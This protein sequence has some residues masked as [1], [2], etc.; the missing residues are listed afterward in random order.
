LEAQLKVILL[1]H[2]HRV[3]QFA[4]DLVIA[5]ELQFHFEISKKSQKGG[6]SDE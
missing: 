4:L 1:E 2:L 3:L 5:L 6:G